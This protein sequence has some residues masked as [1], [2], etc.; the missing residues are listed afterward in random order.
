MKLSKSY[1]KKNENERKEEKKNGEIGFMKDKKQ[2]RFEKCHQQNKID[3]RTKKKRE[4]K[5]KNS[6]RNVCH[7]VE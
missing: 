3:E 5:T 6:N 4:K 2:I 1:N 7:N